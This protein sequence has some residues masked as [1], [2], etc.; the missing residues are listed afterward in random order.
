VRPSRTGICCAALE[1]IQRSCWTRS[2]RSR[3]WSRCATAVCIFC[4]KNHGA[5]GKQAQK[6]LADASEE[7]SAQTFLLHASAALSVAL[8]CGNAD[9]ASRSTQSLRMH[10][11]AVSSLHASHSAGHEPLGD[12]A[13]STFWRHRRAN[14]DR[15]QVSSAFHAQMQTLSLSLAAAAWLRERQHFCAPAASPRTARTQR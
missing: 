3:R 11:A 8:Q 6:L 14:D 2:A 13:A 4:M 15:L 10:Q 9:I 12:A 7:L 5:K 1:V